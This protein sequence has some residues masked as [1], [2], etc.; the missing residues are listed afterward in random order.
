M[1]YEQLST[2]LRER[3]ERALAMGGET[4]LR[5]RRE[6]RQLDARQRVDHLLDPGSFREMGL[7]AVSAEPADREHTPADGK[8]TGFGRIDGRRVAVVSNDLTVKGASSAAVNARKIAFMKEAATRNGMPIV[9]LGESAGARMPDT[10][11]ARAMSHGGADP[12]QYCRRRE[13]PWATAVLGPCYG[14]SSWYTCL[15]DFVAMRRGA[16]LAVSSPRVTSFAIGES[17]DPETLGGWALHCEV[18][19]LVDY[20]TDTD[21]E[22]LDLVRRF[23]SYLPSHQG[24]APPVAPVPDG[25]DAGAERL[26]QIVPVERQRVYDMHKVIEALVDLGSFFALKARYGKAVVTGLARIDGRAVGII[27]PNPKAKGGALDADACSKATA[28]MVLCDSFNLPIVL[29]VDTPGFLVGVE[30]ERKAAPARIMVM[31]HA[32]QLCS[33]PKISVILRK[34]YGQAFLNMGGGRNSDEIAVWVT[35]DVG[36]MDPRA[37]VSVLYGVSR[38]EDPQRY[39]ELCAEQERTNSPYEMAATF[40]AQTV[41]EP[42]ETRRFLIQALEDQR[43]S[44]SGSIGRHEMATWP[45][46]V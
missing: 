4:R 11:G 12:Q 18:T 30:G 37:A 5:R 27:A 28:L 45:T 29:L 36:F 43:R 17:A 9:F 42:N 14:S 10:M 26:A 7:L 19:G 1:N 35:G 25:S 33:V 2:E 20:A 16:V 38:D 22:A 21:E 3:R 15:S 34:S 32:L 31:M 6:A 24:E 40:G 39:D 41:I 8:V 23:L 44:R 46:Y 13:S